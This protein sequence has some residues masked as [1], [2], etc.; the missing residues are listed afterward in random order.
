[1]C[2]VYI[3]NTSKYGKSINHLIGRKHSFGS[4][5]MA[6][7]MAKC[8]FQDRPSYKKTTILSPSLTTVTIDICNNLTKEDFL[9][10]KCDQNWQ[11]LMCSTFRRL[12]LL[13]ILNTCRN[14]INQIA[15]CY[16]PRSQTHP[17]SKL[18]NENEQFM[19]LCQYLTSGSPYLSSMDLY[20]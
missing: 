1:M 4:G 11:N 14:C 2:H 16:S 20:K 19:F 9:V 13:Q 5:V 18:Q 3:Q 17:E 7:L 6:K 15:G 8:A 12:N 10:T